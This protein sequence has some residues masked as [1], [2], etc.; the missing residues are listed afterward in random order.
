MEPWVR[1]RHAVVNQVQRKL[2]T[3]RTN[4]PEP[5]RRV[6]VDNL[7]KSDQR[8]ML[9]GLRVGKDPTCGKHPRV[10]PVGAGRRLP[11]A[12]HHGFGWPR[13]QVDGCHQLLKCTDVKPQA[14]VSSRSK[15]DQAM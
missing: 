11:Q 3:D 6:L 4:A 9:V 12:R 1:C 15:E 2:W 7:D 10:A 14:F 13:R 5:L 8:V